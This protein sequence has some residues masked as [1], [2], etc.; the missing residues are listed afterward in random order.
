MTNEVYRLM[1]EHFIDDD[2]ERTRLE[3]PLVVQMIYDR[4]YTPPAICLNHMLDKM[5]DEVMRR[6]TEAGQCENT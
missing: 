3:K 5:R 4:R 6:A 2:G 1:L